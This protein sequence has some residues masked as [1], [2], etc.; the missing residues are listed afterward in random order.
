[1]DDDHRRKITEKELREILARYSSDL[2]CWKVGLYYGSTI[3]FEMGKEDLKKVG[4]SGLKQVGS[5]TLDL[6]GYRWTISQD[7]TDITD[8]NLIT[9]ELAETVLTEKFSGQTLDSVEITQNLNLIQ[10]HFSNDLK[11]KIQ[12]NI[13]SDY[14][15]EELFTLKFLDYI[16]VYYEINNGLYIEIRNESVH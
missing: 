4:R 1:M 11:I 13:D 3:Y 5:V 9:R 10:F 16:F 14:I 6:D 7:G 12:E 8:N 15:D 2:K